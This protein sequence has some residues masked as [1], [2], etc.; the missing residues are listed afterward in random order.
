MSALRRSPSIGIGTSVPPTERSVTHERAAARSGRGVL[1]LGRSRP[2]RMKPDVE[3]SRPRTA[4][5]LRRELDRQRS[6]GS[7]R[8]IRPIRVMRRA[9]HAAELRWLSPARVTSDEVIRHRYATRRNRPRRWRRDRWLD[10]SLAPVDR[11]SAL[12]PT[13]SATRAG[14]ARIGTPGVPT[15]ARVALVSRKRRSR[16]RTG[17]RVRADRRSRGARPPARSHRDR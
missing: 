13:V 17:S 8:S 4:G 15:R 2:A 11:R 3:S 9:E 14:M 10:H 7:P 12:Y 1:D 16:R 6:P 5:D